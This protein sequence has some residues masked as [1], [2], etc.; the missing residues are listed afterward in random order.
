M[1]NVTKVYITLTSEAEIHG[2]EKL[3]GEMGISIIA[4]EGIEK[5]TLIVEVPEGCQNDWLRRLRSMPGVQEV[6][7]EMYFLA[8][9]ETFCGVN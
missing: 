2:I 7:L 3:I 9:D 1:A 5:K 4:Y 6:L 8:E